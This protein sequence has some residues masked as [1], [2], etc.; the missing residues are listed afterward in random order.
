MGTPQQNGRVERK[1][2]HILNVARALRFQASLPIE[3]WGHCVLGA[4]HLINRTLCEIHKGRSP[5]EILFGKA[6]IYSDNGF[7]DVS[8]ML[9]IRSVMTTCLLVVAESVFLSVTLMRRKGGLCWIGKQEKN[10]SLEMYLSSKINI[11]SLK[12]TENQMC[13]YM[14]SRVIFLIL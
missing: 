5:Y 13:L 8:H 11:P 7:L 6:P 12:L 3:F 14:M 9:T 2:R 4:S 1:N 10:L